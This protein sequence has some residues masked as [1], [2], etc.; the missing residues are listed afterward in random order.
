MSANEAPQVRVAGFDGVPPRT[1]YRLLALRG[2][3]FVVEQAC[4]YPDLDGRDLDTSTLHLWV[5]QGGLPVAYLR[6]LAAG[7]GDDGAE[8][9]DGAGG[10]VRVGRVVTAP[11]ARGRGIASAL[12]RRAVALAGG[13]PVVL[14]AQSHLREWYAGLGFAVDGDEFVEDGIPHVPMRL[15][16]P[17]G[18]DRVGGT[19]GAGSSGGS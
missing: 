4:A 15:L 14:D 5:E 9:G 16:R 6:V 3:V 18:T 1:L 19:A 12:V 11:A 13:R 8:R 17:D 2:E 10:A 7:G